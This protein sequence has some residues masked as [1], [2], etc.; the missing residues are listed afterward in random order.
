MAVLKGFLEVAITVSETYSPL[1]EARK[2]KNKKSVDIL[3]LKRK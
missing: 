3:Y 1:L 2:N